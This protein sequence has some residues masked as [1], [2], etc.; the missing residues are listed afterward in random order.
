MNSE[1]TFIQSIRELARRKKY[2]LSLSRFRW[3]LMVAEFTLQLM[4]RG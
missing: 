3:T 1:S 2:A 4:K